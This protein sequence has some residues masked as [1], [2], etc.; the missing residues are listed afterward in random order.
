[1]AE[2]NE[3]PILLPDG[4]PIPDQGHTPD[5]EVI[6]EP[7][8][9]ELPMNS[10]RYRMKNY[11]R[12]VRVDLSDREIHV[13][14]E[15]Q[16]FREVREGQAAV[17]IVNDLRILREQNEETWK[18]GFIIAA[19]TAVM[20]MVIS[21]ASLFSGNDMDFA[22]IGASVASCSALVFSLLTNGYRQWQ[23]WLWMFNATLWTIQVFML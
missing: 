3:L 10:P 8:L 22:V 14:K 5:P 12:N 21:I 23:T 20:F 15:R 4:E 9:F 13:P 1:M 17:Q 19:I 11:K 6:H 16:G 18:I 2:R 7:T